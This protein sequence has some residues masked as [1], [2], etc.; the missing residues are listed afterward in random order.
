MLQ[1]ALVLAAVAAIALA[2]RHADWRATVAYLRQLGPRALLVPIPSLF[3]YL[4]DTIA[5]RATF[6]RPS[7]FPLAPLWRIRVAIEAV[8][9]SLPGGVAVGESLRVLLLGRRFQ[10]PVAEAA[11]NAVVSRLLMAVAQGAFLLAGVAMATSTH[12]ALPRTSALLEGAGALVFSGVMAG[13][14]LAASRVRPFTRVLGWTRRFAG[15]RRRARLV[16]FEE[17]LERLDRGFAALGRVPRAQ[18]GLSLVMFFV[19][20]LC[21]GIEGWVI[22]RL[23]NAHVALSTAISVE[24]IASMVRI[25]FFFLPGGLGA[26]DV[27]YYELLKFY[28]VPHAEAIAVAFVITKRA[29]ELVWIAV[30]YLLLLWKQS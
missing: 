9:G 7:R 18:V 29:K 22:L 25:G 10:V 24:A 14:L 30:G 17:P 27:S 6:E 8:T 23:L 3:I 1:L 5:W 16:R 15:A 26:Q 21:L 19:G 28:G 20:W 13:I 11:S 12:T 4:S 2:F